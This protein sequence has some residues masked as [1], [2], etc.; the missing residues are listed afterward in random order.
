MSAELRIPSAAAILVPLAELFPPLGCSS[1]PCDGN[2]L[3]AWA[4]PYG[5]PTDAGF[6]RLA[7]RLLPEAGL[8]ARWL[9]WAYAFDDWCDEGTG[10]RDGRVVERMLARLRET[11]RTGH[12]SGEPLLASFADL[13][14]STAPGMSPAW[15]RRF[16]NRLVLHAD[17]CRVQSVNRAYGRV[18]TAGEYPALRRHAFCGFATDLLEPCLRVEVPGRLYVSPP[19][20][21]LVE[22]SADVIAWCNDIASLGKEQGDPHNYV[23]VA[24]ERIGV[25]DPAEWVADRIAERAE[26]LWDAALALPDA[27]AEL[28]VSAEVAPVAEGLLAAPRAFAEWLLESARYRST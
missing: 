4:A 13:W 22:A 1:R 18:P 6:H 11:M 27:C 12:A 3:R 10:S 28:G 16:A 24:A 20:R 2:L 7:G 23:R 14:R 5:L 26:D 9:T 25:L 21:T 19:W 15:T 17:A 8:L